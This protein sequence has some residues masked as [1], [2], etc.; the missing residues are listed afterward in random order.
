MLYSSVVLLTAA[1]MLGPGS[2]LPT[3]TALRP[4]NTHPT[5]IPAF[6]WTGEAACDASGNI[7]VRPDLG[8]TETA[9]FMFS[10]DGQHHQ[11]FK[12]TGTEADGRE[13]GF[14]AY[15]VTPDGQVWTINETPDGDTYAFRFSSN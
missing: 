5:D 7:Y 12:L 14:A 4:T 9:V 1:L 11:L 3:E 10:S 13:L 8:F 6:S 2:T 15:S